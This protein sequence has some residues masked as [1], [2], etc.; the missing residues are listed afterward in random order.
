MGER[1]SSGSDAEQ[2]HGMRAASAAQR[3]GTARE[4]DFSSR[5]RDLAGEMAWRA[6]ELPQIHLISQG[7]CFDVAHHT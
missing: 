4:H 1:W 3:E 7:T 6:S 2:H 5:P